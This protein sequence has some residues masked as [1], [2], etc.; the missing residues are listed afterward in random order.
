M[1]HLHSEIID[2]YTN[3]NAHA[4]NNYFNDLENELNVINQPLPQYV[5]NYTELNYFNSDGASNI[6]PPNYMNNIVV[7]KSFIECTNADNGCLK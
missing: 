7:N 4:F 2:N 5:R 1:N 3:S 6:T